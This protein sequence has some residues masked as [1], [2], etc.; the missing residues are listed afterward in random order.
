MMQVRLGKLV[1][2]TIKGIDIIRTLERVTGFVA[3]EE[4]VR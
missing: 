3:F 1:I 4:C 2:D